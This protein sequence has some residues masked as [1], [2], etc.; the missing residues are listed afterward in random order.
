[1]RHVERVDGSTA[2]R[3]DVSSV[4]QGSALW[5]TLV[6][7]STKIR[8]SEAAE[9]RRS[10]RDSV[11]QF[12]RKGFARCGALSVLTAAR[13]AALMSPVMQGSALRRTLVQASANIRVSEA[14]E[15][16][17]SFRDSVTRF[18]RKGFAR[19]GALSVL[20]ASRL[21]V[22]QGSALWRAPE[23]GFTKIRANGSHGDP[24]R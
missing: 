9:P 3:L 23:P 17:R 11:T 12:V 2:S 24:L 18:V 16:R 1:M 15:P 14:A 13:R 7:A 4:L 10:F 8:V 20:T 21:E 22:L 6:Q 19:C 5:R